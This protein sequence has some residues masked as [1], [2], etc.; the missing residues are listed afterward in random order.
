MRGLD[1]QS[2]HGDP[3]IPPGE[4]PRPRLV[5]H[6]QLYRRVNFQSVWQ[7]Y[8]DHLFP[9]WT[10]R[11]FTALIACPAQARRRAQSSS[12]VSVL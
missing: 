3:I 11:L 7:A 8:Y 2:L 12:P 10:R 4:D 5:G 6:D 9:V 1:L